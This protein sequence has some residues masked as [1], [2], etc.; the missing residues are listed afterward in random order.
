MIWLSRKSHMK[1]RHPEYHYSTAEKAQPADKQPEP[2]ASQE[3]PNDSAASFVETSPQEPGTSQEGPNES[4]ESFVE[5]SPQE[6]SNEVPVTPKIKEELISEEDKESQPYDCNEVFQQMVENNEIVVADKSCAHCKY[7]YNSKSQI[8]R[9][10]RY[11]HHKVKDYECKICHEK[12]SWK[13]RGSHMKSKHPEAVTN[14][15]DTNNSPAKTMTDTSP[16][17]ADNSP[18][19]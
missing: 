5:T 6:P 13:T 7:S 11:V 2:V 4:V 1:L 3:G 16:S 15:A 14:Q 9:H 12:M 8:V 19:K 10:I 18:S 17:K